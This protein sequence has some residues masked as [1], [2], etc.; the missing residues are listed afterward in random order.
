M[1]KNH[2]LCIYFRLVNNNI[3]RRI[4][5]SSQIKKIKHFG[6]NLKYYLCCTKIIYIN[7]QFYIVYCLF[8]HCDFIV[9]FKILK[10][11]QYFC[12]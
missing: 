1:K 7:K 10:L 4:L 11:N 2:N 9:N 12:V 6:L 3:I 5:N 8:T